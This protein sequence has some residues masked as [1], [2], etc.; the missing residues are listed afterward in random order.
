MSVT[1]PTLLTPEEEQRQKQRYVQLGR[2][3]GIANKVN[4]VT[5]EAVFNRLY[6]IFLNDHQLDQ[7]SR[8]RYIAV[9]EAD[10]AQKR[11]D[12]A[13]NQ[14]KQEQAEQKQ[15][16]TVKK[17]AELKEERQKTE[18][19][20]NTEIDRLKLERTEKAEEQPE[21]EMSFE[22]IVWSVAT[23][24]AFLFLV[25]FYIMLATGAFFGV[26]SKYNGLFDPE[27]ISNFLAMAALSKVMISVFPS[28]IFILGL[29]FHALLKK[30]NIVWAII[31]TVV[32]FLFDALLSYKLA[33][34]AYITLHK[35]KIGAPDYNIFMAATDVNFWLAIFLGFVS[36]MA[37]GFALNMDP[38]YQS[39][40][41][42]YLCLF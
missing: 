22:L 1:N 25:L 34:A 32:A 31:C 23:A 24:A 2:D 35:N 16:Q 15:E 33:N 11:K 17:L 41:G 27:S 37:W 39:R 14:K 5:L 9:A 29:G 10:L 3:E 12:L 20:C 8:D 40:L 21:G 38:K 19:D 7:A 6:T 4:P 13:T 42:I 36:Y 28:I 18:Q 30:N 26:S